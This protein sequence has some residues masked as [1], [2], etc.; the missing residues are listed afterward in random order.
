MMLEPLS[1]AIENL[2]RGATFA[3]LSA[4]ARAD[5]KRETHISIA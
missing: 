3:N 5:D 4:G 1:Y 2:Q